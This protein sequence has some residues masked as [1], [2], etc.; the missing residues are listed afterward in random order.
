MLA[1]RKANLQAHVRYTTRTSTVGGEGYSSLVSF[2]PRGRRTIVACCRNSVLLCA[3]QESNMDTKSGFTY[4]AGINESSWAARPNPERPMNLTFGQ[5]AEDPVVRGCA[6][7]P[8][9]SRG[10]W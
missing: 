3:G 10:G 4:M 1:H 9:S 6:G 5:G 2:V 8:N 7:V